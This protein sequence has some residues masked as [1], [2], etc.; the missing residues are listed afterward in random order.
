MEPKSLT[1]AI[2][3][4]LGSS[5]LLTSS[6]LYAAEEDNQDEAQNAEEDNRVIITGSRIKRSEMEGVTPVTVIS[7]EDIQR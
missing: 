7:A 2:G 6:P 4:I 3:L 5:L 1:K